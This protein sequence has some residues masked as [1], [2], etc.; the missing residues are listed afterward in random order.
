MK[1]ISENMITQA[2]SR[3]DFLGQ[4]TIRS[5]FGGYGLLANGIMFAVVSE[6]ELYLRANDKIEGLFR[7]R[8]MANL[9]YAKRG[10]PVLLRY[11][12]VDSQLWDD[13]LVLRNFAR[14]AH[15]G[16]KAEVLSKKDSNVRLKDLPNLSASLER[17]LWKVGIKSAAELRLEGAKCS[18]LKLRVLRRSLGIN[19]LLAL[20]GAISGHHYAVLP[21]MMRIEL[22]EW[23]EM[24]IRAS[25]TAHYETA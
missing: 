3:F 11:Y 15:Q 14:Q 19:V 18:Y 8:G 10:L 2:H 12:W 23:F 6:G 13:D 24:H 25:Q 22:I 4:I 16:A 21:L 5:Q 1:N 7:T 9:V 17:L 20:A